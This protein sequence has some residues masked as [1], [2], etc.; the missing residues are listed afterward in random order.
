MHTFSSVKE[1][2]YQYKVESII[3]SFLTCFNK[4]WL[5]YN[6]LIWISTCTTFY[7][8]V[9]HN[10]LGSRNLI[11]YVC[12][13]H[14]LCFM[15]LWILIRLWNQYKM[16]PN[17]YSI[18]HYKHKTSS[19]PSHVHKGNLCISKTFYIELVPACVIV[20]VYIIYSI[21]RAM[22]SVRGIHI[23]VTIPVM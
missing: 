14:D 6:I 17:Q 18:S 9:Q 5:I 19:W 22:H 11:T 16:L 23:I 7:K 4:I 1:A 8:Q 21:S 20:P 2:V 12:Y 3:T 10:K 15:L 13:I